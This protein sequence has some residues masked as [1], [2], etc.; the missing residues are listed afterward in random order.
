M[1]SATAILALLSGLLLAGCR[2][3]LERMRDEAKITAADPKVPM[4][5]RAAAF[6][7]LRLSFPSGTPEELVVRYLDPDTRTRLRE[8]YDG[9]VLH[10]VGPDGREKWLTIIDGKLSNDPQKER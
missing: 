2:D 1:R 9:F 3:P 8:G 5:K 4:E 6:E 7:K 10:V